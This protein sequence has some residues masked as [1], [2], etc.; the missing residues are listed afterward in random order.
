MNYLRPDEK[1]AKG[2]IERSKRFD[3][4]IKS[5]ISA[6]GNAATAIGGVGLA[7]KAAGPLASKIMPFINKYIPADMAIKGISKVSPEMGKLLRKGMDQGLNVQD[8]LDFIK[9]QIEKKSEPAK[10]KLN[11]IE[12]VSPEL[13]QF[14]D[15]EIRK[16][17][18]PLE[19]GTV[20][21]LDKKHAETIKKLEKQ[22]KTP[23]S[24]IIESLYG[25][26]DQALPQQGQQQA[27]APQQS[28]QQPHPNSAQGKMLA[29]QQ[30]QQGQGQGLDPGVAAILQQGQ[31]LLQKFGGGGQP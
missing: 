9:G 14:I 12:Q 3:S 31:A 16:G 10:Q 27:Q 4:N 1:E 19:A 26:G 29:A 21:R 28:Q 23:W 22:H 15:Q 6:V 11:I 30:A 25:N 13:H 18:K 8:G 20:A 24:K 7:A 17:R 2:D 5:G